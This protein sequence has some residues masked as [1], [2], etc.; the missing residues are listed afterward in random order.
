[1]EFI[2]HYITWSKNSQLRLYLGGYAAVAAVVVPNSVE[3]ETHSP[4]GGTYVRQAR[5]KVLETPGKLGTKK[6]FVIVAIPCYN[7]E[8]AIGTVVL[9]SLQHADHVVVIDDGS[10]DKTT[11]IARMAGAEVVVHETNQ[12]KGAGIRDA[13]RYA[14]AAGADILVLIDGDGQH[15]PDEIPALIEPILKGEADMVNG[16]RFLVKGEHNVP[17]Y[18]RV[19]QEVLT[20]ATTA[21]GSSGITD[22][23]NGFRAFHKRTFGVFTF[24]QNGMAVESE[25]LMDAAKANLKIKEVQINVRY[26]VAGSTYNPITHGFS[27]LGSIIQLISQKRPLLFFCVPGTIM[28]F[29]GM[30]LLFLVL[31][32]FNDTHNFAI[33]YTMLGMLGT[34]IGTFSVFTGLTLA[35]IQSL[36]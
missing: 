26:D 18:R 31:T 12:G 34:I 17:K 6:S 10:K 11:E 28:L 36:K 24:Q 23:Q 9:K 30:G 21:G 25:M 35:S 33:G 15:N 20:I 7:E 27:V 2:G 1:M 5:Q 16:S 4:K 29:V 22:S 3:Q 19:G 13:F 8:I 32:I 14:E